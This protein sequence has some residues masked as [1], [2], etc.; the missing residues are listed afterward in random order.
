METIFQ[1]KK[2]YIN[3][4][5]DIGISLVCATFLMKYLR[6]APN[7]MLWILLSYIIYKAISVVEF[8]LNRENICLLVFSF[9]FGCS[10]VLGYHIIT[11]FDTYN[12]TKDVN[13][14]LPYSFIDI[15]ALG[16]LTFGIWSVLKKIC[17]LMED[18]AGANDYCKKESVVNFKLWIMI[19][20]LLM[21][22][23][24]PYFLVYY[25]GFIFGDSLSSI[26]Q[27]LGIEGLNNHHPI[28]YTLVLKV[29]LYVGMHINDI[30]FGCACFILFQMI[31]VAVCLGYALAWVRRFKLF[32]SI[33][34][35]FI[36]AM[37]GLSPFF[38]QVSIAMWKDP[39]F[40]ATLLV[41]SLV[42]YDL[43]FT[44][45]EGYI[46][47]RLNIAVYI[48]LSLILCFS[49]NTG[50]S[51]LLFYLM[52]LIM[53]LVYYRKT[54]V[55]KVLKR[56]T[57]IMTIVISIVLFITGPV[58]SKFGLQGEPVESLGIFLNQMARVA[59]YD[60][61]MT[62]EDYEFMDALL[63][64]EKYPETYRPCVVDRLKW[65]PDFDQSY[66]N[67]H[68]I[69]FAS[70]WLSMFKQN[71]HCYFQAWELNTFGY[72]AVNYWEYNFDTNNIYKGNL[73]DL[74]T[75]DDLGIRPKNL[76]NNSIIDFSKIFKIEG[77][78]VSLALLNWFIFFL[79]AVIIA[80]K[81]YLW[82]VPLAPSLGLIATLF[83]ATPYTYWQRYGLAE[84]YLIPFYFVA[85]VCIINSN[86]TK[87]TGD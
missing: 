51:V 83:I 46:I 78:V 31:Y 64:M 3:T 68:L 69:D 76:L 47:P 10:I 5:I 39:I 53:S 18:K 49:R 82:M 19:S 77:S 17:V 79:V 55:K 70:S 44:N 20:A 27:A 74:Y 71:P 21:V 12:G 59:A 35:W 30:T 22:C 1:M 63:P 8:K 37:F 56:L 41:L 67:D 45:V 28:L 86:K 66:L 54:L 73:N 62:E 80:K 14:I 43:I 84:Y 2:K 7:G 72:W 60:G 26:R 40:S 33:G 52:I 4:V 50:V 38:G 57:V 23:W 25:P 48:F 85:L 13:Y 36:V 6:I 65:D 58:Y 42:V 75:Q 61:E 81:N 15:I 24:M 16:F 29:F 11:N 87:S 32:S 34:F 9:L